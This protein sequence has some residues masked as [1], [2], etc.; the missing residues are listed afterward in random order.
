MFSSFVDTRRS[1]ASTSKHA[2]IWY[3]VSKPGCAELVHHLLIVAGSFPSCSAS[4]LLVFFFS[5]RTTLSR[6]KSFSFAIL[7]RFYLLYFFDVITADP[8]FYCERKLH[9][10]CELCKSNNFSIKSNGNYRILFHLITS[11]LLCF[12]SP[13]F[14]REYS[15]PIL[16]VVAHPQNSNIIFPFVVSPNLAVSY[17]F[18]RAN[19]TGFIM[20]LQNT[21]RNRRLKKHC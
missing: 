18:A 4:H 9:F 17:H 3:S 6:L 10:H 7:L 1:F 14:I 8:P 21:L 12:F 20:P 2:A 13:A 16:S 15:F 19:G 11:S 5:A